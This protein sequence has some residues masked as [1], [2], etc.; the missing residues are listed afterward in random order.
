MTK[1]SNLVF[2]QKDSKQKEMVIDCRHGLQTP[3]EAFFHQ[4]PNFLGKQFRQV[5]FET[6]GVFSA[7]LSAPILVL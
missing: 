2:D 6:F 5:I 3:N 7:D 1:L 4:Y